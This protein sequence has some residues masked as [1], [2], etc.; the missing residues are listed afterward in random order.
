MAVGLS[1]TSVKSGSKL[2]LSTD[3]LKPPTPLAIEVTVITASAADGPCTSCES[4]DGPLRD[5]MDGRT[6]GHTGLKSPVQSER[7]GQNACTSSVVPTVH[8]NDEACA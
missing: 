6:G 1:A 8:F 3:S 5:D 2:A 4:Q 7:S